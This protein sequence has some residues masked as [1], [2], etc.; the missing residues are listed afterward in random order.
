MNGTELHLCPEE[1]QIL[2][3]PAHHGAHSCSAEGRPTKVAMSP[4]GQREGFPMKKLGEDHWQR[5]CRR[6]RT[7]EGAKRPRGK[8]GIFHLGLNGHEDPGVWPGAGQG[9]GRLGP[10][11]TMWT[12]KE[13]KVAFKTLKKIQNLVRHCPTEWKVSVLSITQGACGEMGPRGCVW[14]GPVW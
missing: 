12:C 9:G 2:R 3:G 14:L 13:E 10:W 4:L 1:S 6:E 7:A 5:A 11:I 8:H